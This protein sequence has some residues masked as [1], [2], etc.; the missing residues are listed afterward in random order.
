VG[1]L[2][3]C[4]RAAVHTSPSTSLVVMC[5]PFTPYVSLVGKLSSACI[6]NKSCQNM[7]TSYHHLKCTNITVNQS[8]PN[9]TLPDSIRSPR[10]SID[11]SASSRSKTLHTQKN[12]VNS[13]CLCQCSKTTCHLPMTHH[14]QRQMF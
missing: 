11:A 12:R 10:G 14:N 4:G 7:S 2:V 3:G 5:D 9:S 13:T 8:N 6:I 1:V